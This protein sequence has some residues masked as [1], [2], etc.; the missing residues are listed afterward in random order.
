MLGVI[1]DKSLMNINKDLQDLGK[2]MNNLR[3]GI[4]QLLCLQTLYK[5]EENKGDE[6]VKR[7]DGKD[8]I[9]LDEIE[10]FQIGKW[11]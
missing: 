3:V 9:S 11:F 10:S 8:F 6:D 5:E 2:E 1:D 4:S 7:I